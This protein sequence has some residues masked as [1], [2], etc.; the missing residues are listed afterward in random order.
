MVEDNN[1]NSVVTFTKTLKLRQEELKREGKEGTEEYT[2]NQQNLVN[3]EE[4][5]EQMNNEAANQQS[6]SD[7]FAS[8]LN[9]TQMD[10]IDAVM[11]N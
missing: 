4:A 9:K 10:I 2:Q 1:S 3:L 8:Q 11:K 7:P 6:L 5:L